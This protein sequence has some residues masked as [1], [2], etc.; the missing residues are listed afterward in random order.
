MAGYV[1]AIARSMV[2]GVGDTASNVADTH[3]DYEVSRNNINM[4]SYD[5]VNNQ[6]IFRAD[7][8]TNMVGKIYEIGLDS[9]LSGDQSAARGLDLAK[10]IP[11]EAWVE[12]T[13]IPS[14]FVDSANSRIGGKLLA[15][16]PA[17]L[18]SQISI[19]PTTIELDRFSSVDTLFLLVNV[20]GT[21]TASI[22]IEFHT[23]PTAY[24]TFNI[25]SGVNTAGYKK[26]AMNKSTATQ[27]SNPD[28]NDINEIRVITTSGSGGASNIGFDGL[29][30]EDNDISTLEE[31]L[32]ARKVLSVPF[33]TTQGMSQSCEYRMDIGI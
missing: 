6:L 2:F 22:Q 25:T 24:Y 27:I 14:T 20:V 10:F 11:D 12:S 7:V 15:H 21:N 3:L 1:P 16:A 5:F 29:R 4:V 28:W 32:V 23:S 26:L 8:P 30:F 13:G 9:S 18:A 17:A 19:L 33:D 31:V